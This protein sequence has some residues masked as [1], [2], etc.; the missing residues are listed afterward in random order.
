M[1]HHRVFSTVAQNG[2]TKTYCDS[3][4]FSG[5]FEK[6]GVQLVAVCIQ[7][8]ISYTPSLGLSVNKN[9]GA[10]SRCRKTGSLYS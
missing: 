5:Y 7:A 10:H 4:S 2:Q 9:N 8:W 1:M 3:R 6:R